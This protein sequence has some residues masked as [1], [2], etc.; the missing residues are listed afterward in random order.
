MLLEEGVCYDQH[1]L[2]AKL[3]A[4]ALFLFVSQGQTYLLLQVSLDFLK[5]TLKLYIYDILRFIF[6][7]YDVYI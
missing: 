7:I 2:L 5:E 6:M 4:F 3:L 1:V